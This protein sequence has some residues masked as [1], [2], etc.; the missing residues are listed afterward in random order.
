M[1]VHYIL[2]D[3]PAPARARSPR[4]HPSPPAS[5][6]RRL[7][8]PQ[9]AALVLLAAHAYRVR[10]DLTSHGEGTTGLPPAWADW[11]RDVAIRAC[12]LP[13]S[14]APAQAWDILRAAYLDLAG[15]SGHAYHQLARN[16]GDNRARQA[17]WLLLRETQRAGLAPEYPAAICRTQYKCALADATA[18]QL[19]RLLYTIRNRA[20][21]RRAS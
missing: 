20:R 3:P 8:N 2:D 12:G 16:P 10:H 21:S 13:I 19:F 14:Q 18:D 4:A 17:M 6:S 9:K 1:T 15:E 11:R 7:T 5:G